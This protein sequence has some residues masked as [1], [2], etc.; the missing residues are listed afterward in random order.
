MKAVAVRKSRFP[1]EQPHEN[2]PASIATFAH[3]KRGFSEGG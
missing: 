1:K 3:G 2:R